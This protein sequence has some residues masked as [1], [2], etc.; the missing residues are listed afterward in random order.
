MLWHPEREQEASDLPPFRCRGSAWA[1]TV[2]QYSQAIFLFLYIIGK[3]LHVKTW[4]G[5]GIS[6]ALSSSC[7]TRAFVNLP[8][9]L[10]SGFCRAVAH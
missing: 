8:P 5:K 2:A 1:N 6:P 9:L 10:S 3:K 7:L 4:G